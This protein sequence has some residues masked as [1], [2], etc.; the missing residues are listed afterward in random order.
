MQGRFFSP[1]ICAFLILA[2]GT[3]GISP[4]CLF[5]SGQSSLIEIEICAADGSFKT[6]ALP[7]DQTPFEAP[8]P[9][10][11]AKHLDKNCAFCFA[12]SHQK[13]QAVASLDILP[14]MSAGDCL[15]TGPGSFALKSCSAAGFKPRAPP[16]F[17]S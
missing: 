6:V 17:L 15:S 16:A 1:L 7:A 8:A 2:L 4:A 10:K 5:I 14:A 3:M 13:T 12:Q 11:P 9:E